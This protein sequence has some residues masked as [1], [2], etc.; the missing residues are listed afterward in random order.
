MRVESGRCR[1]GVDIKGI[2]CESRNIWADQFTAERQHEAIVGQDLLSTACCD[3]YLLFC[4]V[5]RLNLGRQMVNTYRI[6][7]LAERDRDVAKIDLVIADTNVVI[8]VAVDD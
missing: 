1:I 8:S 4:S 6:E 2:G 5:D 7:H 3:G